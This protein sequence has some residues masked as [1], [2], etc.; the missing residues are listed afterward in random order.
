MFSVQSPLDGMHQLDY[1]SATDP[2]RKF[3]NLEAAIQELEDVNQDLTGSRFRLQRDKTRFQN[4]R[5]KTGEKEGYALNQLRGFLEEKGITL[6]RSI[7]ESFEQVHTLRDQLGL[8]EADYDDAEQRYNEQELRFI[9][10]LSHFFDNMS[11]D[12]LRPL[13]IDHPEMIS[14]PAN[15]AANLTSPPDS[16]VVLNLETGDTVIP[17]VTKP[18]TMANASTTAS[19]ISTLLALVAPSNTSGHSQTGLAPSKKGRHDLLEPDTRIGLIYQT[20]IHSWLLNVIST[21]SLQKAFLPIPPEA[22]ELYEASWWEGDEEHWYLTS[23]VGTQFYNDSSTVLEKESS[24][25]TMGMELD[26]L[27]SNDS[28]RHTPLPPTPFSTGNQDDVSPP[29]F[30]VAPSPVQKPQG[31]VSP[32]S[33]YTTPVTTD[34]EAIRSYSSRWRPSNKHVTRTS[35]MTSPAAGCLVLQ[36]DI[37]EDIRQRRHT[38]GNIDV[39]APNQGPIFGHCPDDILSLGRYPIS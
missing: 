16:W 15:N 6:P 36:T 5:K 35:T 30:P 10:K 38:T 12:I 32:Q 34:N 28:I 33:P 1:T 7:E 13:R 9:Q 21:S 17:E 37:R 11:D 8:Q 19:E 31:D 18:S 22:N 14:L 29:Y 20:N 24:G 23:S 25:C 2:K 27:L 26:K 4:I 3:A 39:H